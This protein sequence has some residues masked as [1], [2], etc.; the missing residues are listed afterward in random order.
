ML[1]WQ[2]HKFFSGGVK[3]ASPFRYHLIR[4]GRNLC[5]VF[6]VNKSKW[7][8]AS[9]TFD[10]TDSFPSL[11]AAKAWCENQATVR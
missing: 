11:S 7:L 10:L 3:G 2:K 5:C 9:A 1:T 4:E 6:Q 8:V